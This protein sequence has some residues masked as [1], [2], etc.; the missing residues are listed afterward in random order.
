MRQALFFPA[1]DALADPR[2]VAEVAARAE[3]AGWDGVFVWDHVLYDQVERISD[4]FTC[5]AAAAAATSR[6]AVGPMVTPIQRRGPAL[7]ARQA[8]ALDQLSGGRLV[9]GLGLGDDAGGE[10][11]RLGGETEPR[12]RG[13]QLEEGLELLTGMLSGEELHHMGEHYRADGVRFLPRPPVDGHIPIWLAA[14]WPH[15]RPMRRAARH[16]GLFVISVGEP[17][18]L[19]QVRRIVEEAGA[20]PGFELCVTGRAADDPSPWARAGATWWCC[21]LGPYGLD[22]DE[23]RRV[24]EQGPRPLA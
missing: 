16:D 17:A 23:V 10:L 13:E 4:C 11:S 5:L 20:R 9:L 19:T 2:V 8:V 24:V 22:L 6:I 1:F 21:Q 18:D 3:Q 7:L 12:T 15:R 14:R